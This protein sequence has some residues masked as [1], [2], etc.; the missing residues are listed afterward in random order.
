[1]RAL[2][3]ICSVRNHAIMIIHKW[4]I[5]EKADISVEVSFTSIPGVRLC[6]RASFSLSPNLQTKRIYLYDTAS[7]R[8]LSSSFWRIVKL[9]ISKPKSSATTSFF[10]YLQPP[11]RTF[12]Y[13][14]TFFINWTAV[15]LLNPL[16]YSQ[17]HL[18]LYFSWFTIC[19]NAGSTAVK[20]AIHL[21]M[22]LL[23]IK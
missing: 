9:H 16:L 1:M 2:T 8:Y 10:L 21:Y 15:S 14:C 20:R 17:T 11:R 23:Q 6:Q 4:L 13:Y 5:M 12:L 19:Q 3:C 18:D 7:R 22:F